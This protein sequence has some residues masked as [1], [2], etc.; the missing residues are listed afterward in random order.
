[1]SLNAHI[2]L[3]CNVV[4]CCFHMC[5]CS[6]PP[7]KQ[8]QQWNFSNQY[9]LL[10]AGLVKPDQFF[11]QISPKSRRKKFFKA[12]YAFFSEEF[13]RFKDIMVRTSYI[14]VKWMSNT[15]ILAD[16]RGNFERHGILV[17]SLRNTWIFQKLCGFKGFTPSLFQ[18][19]N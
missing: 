10:K 3:L 15:T 18:S 14:L 8:G 17:L 5:E 9:W 19:Q 2:I 13:G 1:M 7:E 11:Q 4:C 6:L 12:P 16:C